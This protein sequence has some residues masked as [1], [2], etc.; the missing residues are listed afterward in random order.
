MSFINIHSR[1]G[2]KL[3]SISPKK[4]I[5]CANAFIKKITSKLSVNIVFRQVSHFKNNVQKSNFEFN[6][7]TLNSE[8]LSKGDSLNLKMEIIINGMKEEK[9]AICILQDNVIPNNVKLAQ[10]NFICSVKLTQDEYNNTDFDSTRISPENEE[11]N[12]INDL[13]DVFY[14]PKKTDEAIQKIK[15]KKEKA[16]EIT[17]LENVVD[18]LEEEE[19]VIPIFNIESINMEKCSS[20]GIFTLTGSFSEDI[21]ES[22]IFDFALTYPSIEVKCELDE[23]EKG[24]KIEM[25][26][27]FHSSFALVENI[28]IEQKLIR[29]KYK[30]I[31]IIQKK[32]SNLQKILKKK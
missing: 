12:G 27:K 20:S 28:L 6:L 18:Y 2:Q 21:T 17:D 26:C 30:E 7:I 1:K 14:N 29:K 25:T 4:N 24:E 23:A 5:N 10:G 13:D 15:E 8:A 16:E 9:D 31:F 19:K 3:N 32:N 22:M 11:I